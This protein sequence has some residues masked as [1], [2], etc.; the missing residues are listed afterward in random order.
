MPDVMFANQMTR[1]VSCLEVAQFGK[2][3]VRSEQFSEQSVVSSQC[4]SSPS[5]ISCLSLT[6]EITRYFLPVAAAAGDWEPTEFTHTLQDCNVG[7]FSV[8]KSTV[9]SRSA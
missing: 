2:E 7:V 8:Q 1:Q 6:M 4:T 9:F 3:Q 5:R